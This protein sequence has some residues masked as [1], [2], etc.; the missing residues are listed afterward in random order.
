MQQYFV[1]YS[2]LNFGARRIYVGAIVNQTI[3]VSRNGSRGL[4][5]SVDA[6]AVHCD[7]NE[8]RVS[9]C[10]FIVVARRVIMYVVWS[11]VACTCACHR[12]KG[13]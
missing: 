6:V 12:E 1:L 13:M 9:D 7:A 3:E 2:Y 5:F 10:S 4:V 8:S 11:C